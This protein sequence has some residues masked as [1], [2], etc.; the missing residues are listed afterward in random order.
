[1]V[2]MAMTAGLPVYVTTGAS[3]VDGGCLRLH[4]RMAACGDGEW[5]VVGFFC[6]LDSAESVGY[7]MDE[8]LTV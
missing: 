6:D 5:C 4:P 1:M 2:V 3:D 8:I 7:F